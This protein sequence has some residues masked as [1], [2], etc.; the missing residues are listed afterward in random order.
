MTSYDLW[1]QW[2]EQRKVEHFRI[3]YQKPDSE[4]EY[5]HVIGKDKRDE[6]K[7]QLKEKGY[8]IVSCRKLYPFSSEKNQHNFELIR[9]VCMNRIYDIDAG[10]P[11]TD[12]H[13]L[14]RLYDIKEKADK[15]WRLELPV[16]W[17]PWEEIQEAR[18]LCAGA[19]EHRANACIEAGRPDL[20]KYC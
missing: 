16:A 19:I 3:T 18:E 11:M 2:Q 13:E 17:L 6:R 4:I 1:L 7:A 10:E 20:V 9:N 14:E 5:R 8:K 12:E 15:Y